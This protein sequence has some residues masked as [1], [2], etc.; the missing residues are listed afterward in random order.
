MHGLKDNQLLKTFSYIDGSWHTSES[1]FDVTNPATGELLAK[2]SNAGIVETELAVKSAKNAL[3]KW[4]AKSANERASLMRNWFNLMMEHQ[5]DLARILTLEQGKPLAEA[6]GEIGYGAAFVEWF[7]EEGKRVYGDTIP[8]PSGDKRIIVVKQPVGVVAS[9]TPW[10][11]PNAMIARKAAAALSAG[12][13]FVVRPATQTPLSALAMAELAERAGIPAGVFNVVVGTDAS[14][15]GKVLTQHPDIAKFTFTGS[16]A[17]GKLLIS[18]CATTVKKVSMEL[19]GNAPFIVFD[20]ADIDAAVEGA[21]VSKYRNAGQTCV[22]T[23]RIFVQQA[24]LDTFTQKFTAAVEKLSLG[25]GLSEGVNIGP[26]ISATAVNDVDKLVSDSI[27]Q[28]AKVILGGQRDSFGD[29]FYQPTILSNV[30]NDM[31]IARNEI[32]GPVSPIIAF[33]NEE[34]VLAMANDSEYGL[35][36]YFYSRDIGRVWRVAE[37]LEYGMVGINE[38]LISNAAAPFGGVKQSGSGREGSKY[39]LDDYLEIKYLCM[40]GLNK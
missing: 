23:N 17:I 10:N 13:T 1:Y 2:V 30:S 29:T 36:A 25:D 12:C 14:G 6:K 21:M 9:I 4:S 35:A 38:G 3:K 7:A 27:A 33:D 40:G 5:D 31:A 16:T 8:A 37:G 18:Q 20:D 22:C 32:F 28:G 26:M 34:Q 15:I 24:V 39:G 11:F 19:G